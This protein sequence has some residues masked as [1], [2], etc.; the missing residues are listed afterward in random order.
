MLKYI[1]FEDMSKS[2]MYFNVINIYYI[3]LRE[4]TEYN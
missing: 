3:L 4:S 1:F 2:V